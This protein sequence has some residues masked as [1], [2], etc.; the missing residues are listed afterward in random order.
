MLAAPIHSVRVVDNSHSIAHPFTG[1]VSPD[2]ESII[3]YLVQLDVLRSESAAAS[4]VRTIFSAPHEALRVSRIAQR[5]YA[6]RR[7]LGRHF[8]AEGLP[9]PMDWVALAR[10]VCAHRTILR[11]GPLRIAA[12]AAGYPDQFTMSNAIHRI[13]GMRPTQLRNVSWDAL[14]DVWIARQRERGT[15]TGRPESA[16]AT[17]PLCDNL[18]VS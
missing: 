4:H 15:L 11:G 3:A 13:T 1:E 18:R 12:S 6:S 10:A 17:C 14:L 5:T 7:T 8:R 16:P 9:A 2:A